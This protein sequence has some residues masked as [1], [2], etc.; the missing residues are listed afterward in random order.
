MEETTEQ[1]AAVPAISAASASE[2]SESSSGNEIDLR[3]IFVILKKNI[4]PLILVTAIIAA[5]FFVYSKFFIKKQYSA[6]AVLIVNNKTENTNTVANTEIT[7]AQS[8][9]DV[10]S[11]IIKSAAVLQPVV[12]DEQLKNTFPQHRTLTYEKLRN[13]LKVSSVNN[14][15]VINISINNVDASYA[16]ALIASIVDKAP[17]II[18]DR[19]EAGS[20][21]VIQAAKI[22]NNGKPVSPNVTRNTIIGALIGFVLTLA[23]VFI[24]EFTNNTFKTEEDITKSLGIPLLG[25]IPAVDTKEFNKNV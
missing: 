24:R 19:V 16:K 13:A 18:K 9:A 6:D 17:A 2:T 8:L 22:S 12:E 21:N 25:L 10:Y 20:V 4:L 14:T 5:G 23:V 15:Q 3:V 1:I 7:A 11:I